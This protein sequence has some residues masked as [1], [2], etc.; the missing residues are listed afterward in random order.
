MTLAAER[1][2]PL[3]WNEAL[4]GIA[5]GADRRRGPATIRRA[6]IP[7]ASRTVPGG[8][9]HATRFPI[10]VSGKYEPLRTFE[11]GDRHPR[12]DVRDND[13]AIGATGQHEVAVRREFDGIDLV[14]MR[15]E[16]R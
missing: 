9:K 3:I 11:P 8:S 5:L 6:R 15:V 10:E 14:V 13:S 1:D 2:E 7:D 4:R 12:H 16:L